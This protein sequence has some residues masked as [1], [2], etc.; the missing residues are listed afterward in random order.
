M[1]SARSILQLETSSDESELLSVLLALTV[2]ELRLLY[3]DNGTKT[4]GNK[5]AYCRT[6]DC[7][8]EG[9]VRGLSTGTQ[10]SFR[11]LQ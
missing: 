11:S 8:L 2:P 3:K 7:D 4:S 10:C 6:L 1:D 9:S 5:S